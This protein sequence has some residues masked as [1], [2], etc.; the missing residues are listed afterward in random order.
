MKALYIT[1]DGLTDNLGQSQILPYLKGLTQRG[2]EFHILS[3]DKPHRLAERKQTIL[4]ELEGYPIQWTSIPYEHRVKVFSAMRNKWR[5]K[6]AAIRLMKQ[7]GFDV[8]HCRSYIAAEIGLYLKRHYGCK[9]IFD[10]RGF[11]ADERVDG[12]LW[13]LSNPLY[14]AI[15]RYFKRKEKQFYTHA[16]YTIS[17]TE[18]AARIIHNYK[19]FEH[20]PIAVIPCCADL[21]HFNRNAVSEQR[22]N[23][24]REQLNINPTD[25]VLT[26]LGSL[27]TWYMCKEMMDFAHQLQ[28][29]KPNM[30]FLLITS[31]KPDSVHRLATQYGIHNL[32]VVAANR[33]DVP[34]YLSVSS[35]SVFFI[36]P[37]FSKQASSPTKMGEL[38]GMGIPIVA[39]AGVGDVDAIIA[40]THSG[41]VVNQFTAQEYDK[42]IAELD[43]LSL[44]PPEHFTNAAQAYYSLE[45]GV[46]R[47]AKVYEALDI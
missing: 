19:G 18:A 20:V 8:V 26:Y 15:Y 17:L 14:A 24:V 34:A 16:D 4:H 30:V 3:C 9:L 38:L 39:N 27:G 13:K 22:T 21:Q 33:E 36:K 2:L 41:V 31:D 45:M 37:T 40:D 12:G 25:Y 6:A 1:Y 46:E 5:L 10:M 44:L 35:A 23:E 32:R 7:Q 29:H 43:K 11:F 28:A 42:A 47:Y